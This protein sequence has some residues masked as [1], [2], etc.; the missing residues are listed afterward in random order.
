MVKTYLSRTVVILWRQTSTFLRLSTIECWR[1]HYTGIAFGNTFFGIVRH[2]Y[3]P[4][5]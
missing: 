4:E 5:D 2:Q 3:L 1:H